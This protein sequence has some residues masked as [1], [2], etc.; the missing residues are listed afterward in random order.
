MKKIVPAVVFAAM[1]AACSQQTQDSA[2]QT[3]ES[4]AADTK[5]NT[6]FE[7]IVWNRKFGA[8]GHRVIRFDRLAFSNRA[9]RQIAFHDL[10]I[11][12]H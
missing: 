1:L 8:N 6:S 10:D 4:A 9:K 12:R 7:N 11:E 5:A 2:S 3:V